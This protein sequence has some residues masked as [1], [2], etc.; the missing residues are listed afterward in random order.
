M[1]FNNAQAEADRSHP[2]EGSRKV[3][4]IALSV[5]NGKTWPWVRDLETGNEPPSYSLCEDP[6]YSYPSV[7]QSAKGKIQVAF[8]FRK[9]TIKFMTFD[10]DWIKQGSTIGIQT[11]SFNIY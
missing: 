2:T 7:T 3:L 10:E 11:G 4:S 9:E 5:D 1:V 8:S 6:E